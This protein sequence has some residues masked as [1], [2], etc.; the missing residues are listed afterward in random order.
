MYEEHFHTDAVAMQMAYRVAHA[1]QIDEE[2]ERV[3]N[4]GSVEKPPTESRLE[5]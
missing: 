3:L 2:V 1:K 4:P 5:A